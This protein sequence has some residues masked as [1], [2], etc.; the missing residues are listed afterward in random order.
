MELGFVVLVLEGAWLGRGV[1][2]FD[3]PPVDVKSGFKSNV[4]LGL[5]EGKELTISSVLPPL[6]IEL[7]LETKPAVSTFP[8]CF[9]INPIVTLTTLTSNI[10]I[11]PTI[12]TLTSRGVVPNQLQHPLLPPF[13]RRKEANLSAASSST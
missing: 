2:R 8:S 4:A 7:E 6:A 5:R 9:N 1:G 12:I 11:D 3:A 13:P 10:R